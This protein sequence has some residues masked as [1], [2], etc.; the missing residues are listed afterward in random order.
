VG[1]RALATLLRA[2]S[3]ANFIAFVTRRWSRYTVLLRPF[4]SVEPQRTTPSTIYNGGNCAGST[5]VF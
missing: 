1:A 5:D 2:N 3:A 4:R